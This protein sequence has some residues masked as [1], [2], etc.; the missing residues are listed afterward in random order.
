M[1]IPIE[2]VWTALV[3]TYK[4]CDAVYHA[5]LKIK[6]VQKATKRVKTEVEHIKV[7]MKDPKSS[8]YNIEGDMYV[9][10]VNVSRS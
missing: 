4:L 3:E 2:Q 10:P 8:F 1:S 7:R 5:P 6:N 9:I